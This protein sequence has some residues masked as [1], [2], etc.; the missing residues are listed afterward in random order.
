MISLYDPG[1]TNYENNG[2]ITLN[3]TSCLLTLVVNGEW[4][5]KMVHP[6]DEDFDHIVN[7]A[8]IKV[9][10]PFGE[11]CFLIDDIDKSDYDIQAVA[12]PIALQ[13]KGNA[14]FIF[15]KRAV[16]VNGQQALDILFENS[17]YIGESDIK[18]TSTAYWQNMNVIEAISGD[19]D[20]SFLN[21]WGGEIAWLNDRIVI[22]ERLGAD[23]G[24]R[25]EFG[26]NLTGI[27]EN[28]SYQS[29]VTRI[30]PKSYNGYMLPNKES[31]DSPNINKYQTIY[32]QIIE[33]TDIKLRSDA[34]ESD[35]ENGITLC[36]TLADL[37]A[38]LRERASKEF[39]SGIDLPSISYD[40]NIVALERLDQFKDIANLVALHLGDT[41]HV[42]HR[43]L[44]IETIQRVVSME[45]DCC[46]DKVNSM[47]LGDAQVTY[48]DKVTS[49]TSAINKVIDKSTNTVIADKI[50]GII[51]ASKAMLKAQKDVSNK[52]DVRAVLFEDIDESSPTY[53]ALCIGTQGI[54]ISKNRNESNTDW[55]WGTAITFESVIADYIITGILSDHTGNFYLDLD[56]GTLRMMNGEFTGNITG[57]T[58]SGG[59]INVDTDLNVGNKI[60]IKNYTET[61]YIEGSYGGVY[62]KKNDGSISKARL[63]LNE[64]TSGAAP[65][66]DVSLLTEKASIIAKTTQALGGSARIEAGDNYIDIGERTCVT[67][68][69][70]KAGLTGTFTVENSITIES[71]FVV[72]VD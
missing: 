26:Y 47:T 61:E 69:N 33:Y 32:P 5:L 29:I 67:R 25:A 48:F 50:Q 46:L 49:S 2:N 17:S 72:G 28:I 34:Q 41:V 21:R 22:N 9:P 11:L 56:T 1:N 71:G 51:N 15:D 38:A 12:H 18:T 23:N 14:P 42:K 66:H 3:P 31:V 37:Y 63:S 62:I 24:A 52:S 8:V 30:Y 45:Y 40:V 6:I 54:E 35:E 7:D 20:N 64:T 10:S 70:G 65:G 68:I 39:E 4:T 43:R 57:S 59:T 55:I 27:S 36:D 44:K 13:A 58:I 19:Q 60:F 53:G 16:N